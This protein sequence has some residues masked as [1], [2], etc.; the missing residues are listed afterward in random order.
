MFYKCI[1]TRHNY[2]EYQNLE[3]EVTKSLLQ[4]YTLQ[5]YPSNQLLITLTN[6]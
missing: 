4:T 2:H 1:V 5:R 3:S 6:L